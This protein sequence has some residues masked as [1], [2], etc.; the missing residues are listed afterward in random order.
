MEST[1][2]SVCNCPRLNRGKSIAVWCVSLQIL[3]AFEVIYTLS[4]A[5]LTHWEKVT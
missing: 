5:S 3:G 4:N 2:Q 1:I